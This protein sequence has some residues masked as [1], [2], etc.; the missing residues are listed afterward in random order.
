MRP[1]SCY[2]L[3]AFAPPPAYGS[4]ARNEQQQRGEH[5]GRNLGGPQN[6]CADAL[7]P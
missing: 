1:F 5:G 3:L 7:R 2:D 6:L 4:V